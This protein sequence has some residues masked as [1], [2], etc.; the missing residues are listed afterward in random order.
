MRS[1]TRT[2]ARRRDAPDVV[3]AEVQQ[4]HVLGAFLFV[5]GKLGRVGL[6]GFARRP[7]RT[8]PGDRPQ[9]DGVPFLADQNLR[10]CADDMEVAEIVIEH[11]RRRVERAQRP[12]ERQRRCVERHRQPLRQHDLHDVAGRDISLRTAHRVAESIRADL[13][14][15]LSRSRTRSGTESKPARATSCAAA[16]GARA[17]RR[18]R[19]LSPDRRRRSARS[20]RRGCRPPRAR[21]SAAAG[22]RAGRRDRSGLTARARRGAARC[23]ARCRSRSSRRALRRSAAARAAARRDSAP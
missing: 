15:R 20:C 14:R 6:V 21:R 3:A 18:T 17:R 13:A 1:V 10:R 5:G 23:G 12:V 9:R 16:A 8:S 2:V 7:A 22:C 11:V 4:H 19:S